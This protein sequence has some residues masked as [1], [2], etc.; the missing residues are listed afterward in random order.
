MDVVKKINELRI[1][2][3]L[4]IYELALRTNLS[5]ETV[6]SWLNKSTYPTLK[7]IEEICRALEISMAQLFCEG[8]LIEVDSETKKLYDSFIFLSKDQRQLIINLI[9]S[10]KDN[11]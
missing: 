2:K 6:Y 1:K 4:S 9:N 3:G 11:K 10:Y 7:T 5:R 8:K